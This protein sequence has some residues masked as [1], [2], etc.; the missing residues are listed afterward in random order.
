MDR[1]WLIE[2]AAK[3][4]GKTR[5][6]DLD[7][8]ANGNLSSVYSV[9][10]TV[11]A[12]SDLFRETEDDTYGDYIKD[13][14]KN[15][16]QHL[17]TPV[18]GESNESD[19]LKGCMAMAHAC[20]CLIT[21]RSTGQVGQIMKTLEEWLGVF[22]P[23]RIPAYQNFGN[24]DKVS[25]SLYGARTLNQLGRPGWEA[26]EQELDAIV[27]KAT[28]HWPFGWYN[29]GARDVEHKADNVHLFVEN[30]QH[31]DYLPDYFN[32]WIVKDAATLQ[33]NTWPGIYGPEFGVPWDEHKKKSI[34]AHGW[35][36]LAKHNEETRAFFEELITEAMYQLEHQAEPR[37][38]N[39]GR[40]RDWRQA[41]TMIAGMLPA[42]PEG[43][44]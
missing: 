36:K 38:R 31:L 27:N 33:I 13:I 10:Y 20:K 15:W 7:A 9:S 44:E 34:V 25:R 37:P 4:F 1:A 5:Q 32:E 23:A 24:Y 28:H 6:R 16:K 29:Y 39:I 3:C 14:C 12:C 17:P 8:S 21:G 43:V 26:Y 2:K 41:L 35:P 19:A 18:L 22:I 30:S 42:W 11:I 40:H